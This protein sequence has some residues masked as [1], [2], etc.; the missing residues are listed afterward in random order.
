MRSGDAPLSHAPDSGHADTRRR[1]LV[2]DSDGECRAFAAEALHSFRP[3]F[4][5][6]T[7]R[8]LDEAQSWLETFQPDLVLVNL[9]E[10]GPAIEA[11]TERLGRG[12][13]GSRPQVVLC[14]DDPSDEAQATA[15]TQLG[16]RALLPRPLDLGAL[17]GAVRRLT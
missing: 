3:G 9:D 2:I 6:A 16:A 7:A 1:A 15:L 4:D 13:L 8:D 14:V 11:L 12:P 17:L 10:P 5:V